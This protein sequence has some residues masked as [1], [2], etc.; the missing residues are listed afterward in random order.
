M[1]YDDVTWPTI[2][3][4][5]VTLDASGVHILDRRVFPFEVAFVTCETH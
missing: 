2:Y 5:S 1:T 3:S 4:R